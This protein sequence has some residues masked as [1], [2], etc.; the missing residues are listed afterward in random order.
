MCYDELFFPLQ[1]YLS[2][3]GF[4]LDATWLADGLNEAVLYSICNAKWYSLTAGKT[5]DLPQHQM[6]EV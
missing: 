3:S 1:P 6:Q 5:H 2:P 4:D